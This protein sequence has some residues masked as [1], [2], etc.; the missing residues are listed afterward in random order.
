MMGNAIAI[1]QGWLVER[2]SF[3]VVAVEVLLMHIVEIIYSWL[4][5][6]NS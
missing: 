6:R 3:A 1:V 4:L 5:M 2:A